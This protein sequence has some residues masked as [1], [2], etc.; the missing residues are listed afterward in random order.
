[1][2]ETLRVE[3]IG[4]PMLEEI[5]LSW[6]TD[7][8]G[9]P[10]IPAELVPVT[11]AEAEAYYAAANSLYDMFISAAQR[12]VDEK[13][14]TDLGIPSNLITLI[15]DSWNN[16]D[17]HL[18]G[19][20]D[21]AGGLDGLPIKLIE[22][23]ADTPTSV[24]ETSI[25]QWAL[26]KANQMDERAQ[27][28]N[29]HEMLKE[30]FKRLVT[31]D[32]PISEFAE[33]YA[34]EKLLFSSAGDLP[35][36][37]QTVRYLQRVAHEAGFFT[38]FCYLHEAGFSVDGGIVNADQQ[39]ADYWFKLF[40]WEDI[41]SDELELT[42]ILAKMQADVA[43]R[44]INPA[45]TLL[46]QSKGLLVVLAEMF[47]DS[48]YLL[49]AATTPLATTP[50]V[51]KPMFGREGNNVALYDPDGNIAQQA[52]GPYGHHKVVYQE[53]AYYPT[54]AAGN[55]YQ[56]GVF[57]AWEA[58]ALGFRRGGLIL[59]DAAKFVGHLIDQ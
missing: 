34:S 23:N 22:F 26:L 47:P 21:F 59:D 8:D 16:D 19:R 17:L 27:F 58:C 11:E 24:F 7:T 44:I 35:E 12:V 36:D 4:A 48:P 46:F 13:L 31:H 43:T 33:R 56:A 49:D 57:Y 14:Y 45:Y 18:Y 32:K 53:R 55:I 40:P 20:F 2:I 28:N 3:P 5:G 30:N 25:V 37:E 50:Q 54:D 39:R 9:T 1:M 29:L 52:D 51:R 42:R 6:H 15:E 10:Y 41:A 38:D